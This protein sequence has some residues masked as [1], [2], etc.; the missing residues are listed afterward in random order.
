VISAGQ[1]AALI[2]SSAAAELFRAAGG[3]GEA[4]GKGRGKP[5]GRQ[6]GDLA[7]LVS[8]LVDEGRVTGAAVDSLDL[9]VT[10]LSQVAGRKEK[11]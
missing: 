2:D 10:Q 5:A 3:V 11:D 6:I 1:S 9:A 8:R 4:L 7:A